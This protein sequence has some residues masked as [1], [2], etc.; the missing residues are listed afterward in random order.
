MAAASAVAA[1]ASLIGKGAEFVGGISKRRK[2]KKAQRAELGE[3]I[4]TTGENIAG[5]QEQIG[6][7]G[8]QR[9]QVLGE[10][11]RATQQELGGQ[12]AGFAGS[13]VAVGAGGSASALRTATQEIRGRERQTLKKGFAVQQKQLGREF[14]QLTRKKGQLEKARGKIKTKGLRG[15]LGL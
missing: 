7:L 4:T 5:T 1:G 9:T 10:Q 11:Q 8:E 12:T 2:E 14:G 6:L 3:A 15:L 13:G